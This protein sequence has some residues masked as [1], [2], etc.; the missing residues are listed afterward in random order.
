MYNL[1]LLFFDILNWKMAG[2]SFFSFFFV[3]RVLVQEK[4]KGKRKNKAY[5]HQVEGFKKANTF[6]LDDPFIHPIPVIV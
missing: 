3:L 5:F 1:V 4:K 2:F 6:S